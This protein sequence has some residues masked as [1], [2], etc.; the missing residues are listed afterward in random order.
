GHL[1]RLLM[2]AAAEVVPV[3]VYQVYDH[4]SVV[5]SAEEDEVG[6]ERLL[7]AGGVAVGDGE[8]LLGGTGGDATPC[9]W[10]R[11][12]CSSW[13]PQA[14]AATGHPPERWL[15]DSNL[16][17]RHLP[18]F[19]LPRFGLPRFGLVVAQSI[20]Q[21]AVAGDAR[22]AFLDHLAQRRGALGEREAA[23]GVH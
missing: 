12:T 22:P 2:C 18:R 10:M 5:S 3:W 16:W 8:G 21:G 23:A 7:V 14:A 15:P 17:R 1:G 9:Q 4:R 6:P 20:G 13:K 19:G 11:A